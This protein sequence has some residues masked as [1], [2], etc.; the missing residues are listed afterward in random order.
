MLPGQA[1]IRPELA[2]DGAR[3]VGEIRH[4][5]LASTRPLQRAVREFRPDL[6]AAHT[7]QA[8]ALAVRAAVGPPV[9]VHRRVDF[10]PKADPLTRARY[11]K[12]QGY[13]AVSGAVR[14]V[15]V[16]YGLSAQGIE[17]VHDGVEIQAHRPDPEAGARL[18]AALDLP[19]HA[20]LVGSIGALVPHKG[21]RVLVEAMALIAKDRPDMWAVIAGD[22][23]ERGR[24][25]RQVERL[26]APVQ[27]LGQLSPPDLRGLLGAIDLLVHPSVEEGL[28]QSV[29]EAMAGGVPVLA[30][31]AGG[32][33]ELV[34]AG[35]TG[36]LVPPGD[37]AALAEA[38]RA[39]L[40]SPGEGQRL[41]A[42]ALARIRAHHSAQIMARETV[43]A[44]RRLVT[45]APTAS[46]E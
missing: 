42:G 35:E 21:H 40:L 39:A 12:A 4:G 32:L 37:P 10:V 1:L 34:R 20:L 2:A 46:A 33:P 3:I 45:G 16:D 41:A 18:R 24:L 23:S 28:G 36:R 31:A 15:L 38:T 13:V 14:Q 43:E 27:L 5:W 9:I 22:G 7:P 29:I 44:Y 17:V 6:I 26:K 25:E 8:H 11:R 19:S 30:S